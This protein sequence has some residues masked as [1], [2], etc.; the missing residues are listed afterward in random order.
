[1]SVVGCLIVKICTFEVLC[2]AGEAD[3]TNLRLVREC[4]GDRIL[5]LEQSR[6]VR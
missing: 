3:E 5:Q 2:W 6:F 4:L 1:V